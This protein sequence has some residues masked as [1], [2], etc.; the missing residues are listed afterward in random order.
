MC[1]PRQNCREEYT[2]NR[3]TREH[4]KQFVNLRCLLGRRQRIEEN[5]PGQKHQAEADRDPPQVPGASTSSSPERNDPDQKQYGCDSGDVEREYLNYECRTDIRAQHD[6]QRRNQGDEAA[7]GKGRGHQAGRG[8]ALQQ[9]RYEN[10]GQ[11]CRKPISKRDVEEVA[12]VRP[13]R[14]HDPAVNHVEA[15]EQEGHTA[16]QIEKKQVYHEVPIRGSALEFDREG[17]RR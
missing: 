13:E 8:A 11:E 2:D 9:G 14:T 4:C 10:A 15:P 5:V 1:R 7:C 17:R 3:L 12:E 6:R 16:Q